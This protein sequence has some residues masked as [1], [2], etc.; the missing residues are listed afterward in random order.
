MI[1]P[2]GETLQSREVAFLDRQG[3]TIVSS[4]GLGIGEGGAHEYVRIRTL[5]RRRSSSR[6]RGRRW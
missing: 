1:S 2:Y 4:R 5:G 6:W 3:F